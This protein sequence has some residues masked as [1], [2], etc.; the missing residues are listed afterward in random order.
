MNVVVFSPTDSYGPDAIPAL[1][2]NDTVTIVCWGAAT[3]L[4][5]GRIRVAEGAL[6]ARLVAAAARNVLARTIVRALPLDTGARFWRATRSHPGITEAVRHADLIVAPER[7][8]G[9]A[10]WSWRRLAER[11]GRRITAVA[12]YPAARTA[13]AR[14]R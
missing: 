2:G 12:G 11:K 7:D 14:A 8:G 6:A 5:D 3:E 10:A 4:D 13:I 1:D 9:F